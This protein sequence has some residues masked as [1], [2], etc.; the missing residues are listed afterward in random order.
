METTMIDFW[1]RYE[2]QAI[3]SFRL[4]KYVGGD[5][6]SA[7]YWTE[8]GEERLPAALNLVQIDPS[9][10]QNRLNIWAA[11]S[12][13]FHPRLIR[14][15]ESGCCVIEGVD[16]LFVVTER[17]EGNLAGVLTVRPLT[18]TVA[19]E[20]LDAAV[21]ALGFLHERGFTHGVLTP[22]SIVAVGEEVKLASHCVNRSDAA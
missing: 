6:A 15:F 18:A 11:L 7:V 4:D 8:Y 10:R 19:R 9:E 3:H 5:N 2:G 12:Q 17:S 14:I 22:S 16:L 21:D 13:F 1:A 20:M